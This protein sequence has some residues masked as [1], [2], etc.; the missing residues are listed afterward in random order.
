MGIKRI[1]EWLSKISIR[2]TLIGIFLGIFAILNASIIGVLFNGD[3]LSIGN[4]IKE[5]AKNPL[6]W[7]I[8][9]APLVLGFTFYYAGRKEH[10]IHQLYIEFE[11]TIAQRTQ[12]LI[13]AN[14]RLRE[15]NLER[16][17][18]EEIISRGK[19]EWEATFDAVVDMIILVDLNGKI[20]RCNRST[21]QELG[22]TFND[23]IGKQISTVLWG[24]DEHHT[25]ELSQFSGIM[26][27]PCLKGWFSVSNYPIVLAGNPHGVIHIIRDVTQQRMAELEILR[28]KQYFEALV[29]NS[30]IAVVT[31]ALDNKISSCNPAFETLFGFTLEEVIGKD[32]DTL[33]AGKEFQSE[34]IAY[35]KTV[36]K[37]RVIHGIGQRK[38]K[39]GS[40]LDVEIFG[41]PVIVDGEQVGVLGLYNNITELYRARLEAEEADRA[42][43]EFLANMS[44]EIRTPMNGIIGMIELALGT[45]LTL[46]QRD[47]LNTALESADALLALLNDILDF[48]KIEARRLEL[49]TIDFDLRSTVEGVA[50]MMAQ[51]AYDKNLEMACMLQ[52]NIPTKLR[53]DPGRLRQI[54]INLV[55]N[56]IKFTHKGEIVIH[57]DAVSETENALEVKFFVRDTGIGIPK[58][59]QNAIFKRFTQ[60]DGSTTRKYGGTGLGLSISKQLV[61]LMGGEIGVE[62][63]PGVGSTFWFSVKFEKQVNWKEQPITSLSELIGLNVLCIDDNATN[64]IILTKM[65]SS[66]GCQVITAASGEEG[67]ELLRRQSNTDNPIKI[68][69]IDMQMPE[70]DG[71]QTAKEI[72]SDKRIAPVKII[73]LTSI[74]QR[75]D[76]KFCEEIGC[77]GYLL[78]PIRK[79]D[80]METLRAIVGQ[81]KF[82]QFEKTTNLVTRHSIVDDKSTLSPILLAEDNPINRKLAVKLLE[83]T[84]YKVKTVENGLQAIDAMHKDHYSLVLMDVQ[85]PEM[86]GFETTHRIREMEGFKGK[87]PI[88]AMTAHA[89][90]GDREKCIEAGMNDYISKPIQPE[91]LFKI[92]DRWCIPNQEW[93]EEPKKQIKPMVINQNPN[94]QDAPVFSEAID[95]WN[96]KLDA[97]KSIIGS[98]NLDIPPTY[99][100]ENHI[101]YMENDELIHQLAERCAINENGSSPINLIEALPRFNNDLG[102]F[103]TMLSEFVENIADRIIEFK[104]AQNEADVKVLHRLA[105]SL[106]GMA[107][108]F[109][110]EK[111]VELA[112]KL[113]YQTKEGNLTDA[114]QLIAEIESEIP[115]I[116]YFLEKFSIECENQSLTANN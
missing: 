44:H 115:R 15:E 87:T 85:M 8:D 63:E 6:L 37:G 22:K 111:I 7:I 101:E 42:K 14:E 12:E 30:P 88:I 65:I 21:I 58:D 43:S 86:D 18:A 94:D 4:I 27:F 109:N 89:M 98:D 107:L 40:L 67:L 102:F 80:L 25:L 41:V 13:N 2:Y 93:I 104:K 83:K 92:I 79:I 62:S 108:N 113:E 66:F 54:L 59:R 112:Q 106:K 77:S 55:S 38:K 103:K 29:K 3:T 61:E 36:M 56:A 46:E 26:Q 57:V 11:H 70:M 47:Y 35:T 19:K 91:E 5:H 9:S 71:A 33:I 48:S 95:E 1:V 32:L 114:Q 23:V 49:E 74:G 110:A 81:S 60:A 97:G 78:K 28:Q 116:N 99:E 39:D 82:T 64:R 96:I 50:A 16:I 90:S 51:K 10:N 75:G 100:K 24:D 53:G 20:I 34:A 45:E 17:R 84:G 72:F 52:E 105:H 76:A 31:I 73:M 69:F 68:V